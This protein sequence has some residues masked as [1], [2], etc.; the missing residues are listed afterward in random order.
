MPEQNRKLVAL[1]RRC[2]SW[3]I[4][5]RSGRHKALLWRCMSC[6]KPFTTPDVA[7]VRGSV[8]TR[9]YV[10]AADISRLERRVKRVDPET[11]EKP[12][13]SAHIHQG[14]TQANTT[15]RPAASTSGPSPPRNRPPVATYDSGGTTFPVDRSDDRGGLGCGSW[16]LIAVLVVFVVVFVVG[17]I[18]SALDEI[19]FNEAVP[20]PVSYQ[21]RQET[22]PTR[23]PI[24][25]P[26]VVPVIPAVVEPTPTQEPTV[27]P[28]ATATP[29]PTSIPTSTPSPAAAP[30]D[31]WIDDLSARLIGERDGLI[32]VDFSVHLI[33]VRGRDGS[34]P[35][36]VEAA[37]DGGDR[38]MIYIIK[39]MKIGEAIGFVFQR[40]L[41]PGAM[42]SCLPLKTWSG[43]SW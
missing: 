33:N 1:C 21:A 30:T 28:T 12:R 35:V 31:Y 9:E 39:D 24:P 22:V 2:G 27:E 8:D 17:I 29:V 43:R 34:R 36:L 23:T 42:M 32:A 19:D 25:A 11:V 41:T 38:E 20:T 10:L 13:S 18:S 14:D 7:S 3:R 4:R 26:T 15:P 16:L 40:E 5:P 37:L 6:G